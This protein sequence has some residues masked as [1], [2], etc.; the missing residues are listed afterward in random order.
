MAQDRERLVLTGRYIASLLVALNNGAEPPCLPSGVDY[1]GIFSLAKYHSLAGAIWYVLE[2]RLGDGKP[3]LL[4]AWARERDMDFAKNLVQTREFARIT[5]L[6]SD[7][8]IAYLTMKGF[9]FKKLWRRPEYRTMS[10]IDILVGDANIERAGEL[11]VGAGYKPSHEA[12]IHDSYEK[13]PY[14]CIELHRRLGAS[15]DEDFGDW[16]VDGEN[17]CHY[18]QRHEDFLVF[19]VAHAFKHFTT[20]GCGIR[21]VYD[22]YLYVKKYGDEIDFDYVNGRLAELGALEFYNNVKALSHAWFEVLETP[23]GD[24]LEFEYYILKGGTY[25]NLENRVEYSMKSKSRLGYYFSRAFV[26]YSKMVYMYPWLRRLPFLLPVAWVMRLVKA[27]F[28]GRL[29]RELNAIDE[30][31]KRKKGE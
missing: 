29:K 15:F 20:G 10:D 1:N 3:E 8:G 16:I 13:P 22:L 12:E 6:F 11:L 5:K 31:A 23:S 30:D 28:D 24:I 4:S 2:G 17:P 27:L 26:P 14:M 7:N 19:T 9:H 18:Y 21:S 25:G